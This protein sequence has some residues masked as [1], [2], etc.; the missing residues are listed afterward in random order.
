MWLHSLP[1]WSITTWYE[2][3]KAFLTKFFPPSRTASLRNQITT[4]AQKEDK[5]L[6]EA[7]GQ[8]KDL[9]QLCPHDRLRRW[10]IVKFFY[11]G[12]TQPVQSTIDATAGSTLMNTTEDEAYHWIEEMTLNH[13]QWSNERNQPKRVGDKLEFD[14]LTLLSDKVDV[15]TQT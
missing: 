7:W 6:C 1:P 13:Y 15:T 9:L 10:M 14:A 11:N 5:T 3:T 8:F 12:V 2:L 4:F